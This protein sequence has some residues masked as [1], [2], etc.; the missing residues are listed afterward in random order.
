[1]FVIFE[2]NDV[3]LVAVFKTLE[4]VCD[5]VT[6]QRQRLQQAVE[7]QSLIINSGHTLVI[8]SLKQSLT[9]VSIHSLKL[10]LT[11]VSIHSSGSF[12]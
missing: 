7:Q 8:H 12:S 10:P 3:L 6:E 5:S 1:V 9:E 4:S 2:R 11:E